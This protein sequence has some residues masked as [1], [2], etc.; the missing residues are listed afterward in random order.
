MKLISPHQKLYLAALVAASVASSHA[1]TLING[2]FETGDFTGWTATN[3]TLV[4]NSTVIAGDY[5]ARINTG[6]TAG[7]TNGL[8]QTISEGY[9]YLEFLFTM[10]N[11]GGTNRGL[12]L[13]VGQET[14]PSSA[15]PSQ[16]NLRVISG[17]TVQ[18]FQSGS[19]TWNTIS[20]GAVSYT[21][22]NTFSMNIN[23]LGSEWNYDITVN[24][25]SAEN[26]SFFQNGAPTIMERIRFSPG[27]VAY[28][29][30]NV[31][32]TPEP[33]TALLG[34]LGMLALLRRRR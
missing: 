31:S 28:T 9:S 20:T 5:S 26:L 33:S 24:G 3:A 30:D 15:N 4:D 6:G 16:I 25:T 2:D 8:Y 22:V 34:G 1:A 10:P 7:P 13:I 23:G 19:N 29:V 32:I 21:E 17:G 14:V 18:I 27:Q 12:N 11:P